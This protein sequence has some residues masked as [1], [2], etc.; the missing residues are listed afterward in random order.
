[1]PPTKP[2]ENQFTWIN[3]CQLKHTPTGATFSWYPGGRAD[4]DPRVNPGN[5]GNVLPTGED[6][7]YGEVLSV[8]RRL[9]RRKV[10][11]T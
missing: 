9:W 5:L 8:A 1:M 10:E 3:S 11:G 2:E 6:F 4:D 7:D